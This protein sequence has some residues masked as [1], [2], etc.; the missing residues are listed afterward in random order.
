[1][2]STL[3]ADPKPPA[4]S[5]A[6]RWLARYL[7]LASLQS[8]AM[9]LVMPMAV[10][11]SALRRLVS[12]SD[13]AGRGKAGRGPRRL[14]RHGLGQHG[15]DAENDGAEQRRKPD[16]GMEQ[17]A[18]HEIDRQPGQVEQRGWPDARQE[19]SDAVE[20]AQRLQP[21]I[22][23]AD[24]QRQ[25]HDRLVNPAAER[26]VEAAADTHQDAAADQI[27]QA[28]RR[29]EPAGEDHE[30]DQRR[31]A[32]ARQ[33]AVVDLQHED[34]AGQH[35]DVAHAAHQAD[36]NEC[37]AASGERVPEF[38][39]RRSGPTMG[40]RINLILRND[41]SADGITPPSNRYYQHLQLS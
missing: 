10:S 36:R 4:T 2:R 9:R 17:K 23:V 8:M 6:R 35:E 3:E 13:C 5:L 7:V 11:T 15:D 24:L 27:E 18:D 22:A 21:V 33:H 26:L 30:P 19:R 20:I 37:T 34:R 31:H 32:A 14:A 12:A 41:T 25:T 39:T 1:M 16:V 38:G 28:Q 40:C 29:V